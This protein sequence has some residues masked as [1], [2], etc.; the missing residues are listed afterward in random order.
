MQVA[1]NGERRCYVSGLAII[2]GNLKKTGD[3]AG[4][5]SQDNMAHAKPNA[6]AFGHKDE[7]CEWHAP[8]LSDDREQI[9]SST[10]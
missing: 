4:E 10:C 3:R 5:W 7:L 2:L 6:E 8:M 9:L 1:P